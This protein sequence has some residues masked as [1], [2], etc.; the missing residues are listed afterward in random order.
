[1]VVALVAV[2]VV[3]VP[4]TSRAA[5]VVMAPV[6]AMPIVMVPSIVPLA[7]IVMV[8]VPFAALPIAMSVVVPF[9]IPAWTDDNSGRR[10]DVHRWRRCIDRLG[11]IHDTGNANIDAN[12]DVR[13]CDG[14]CAYANAGDECYCQPAMKF[15]FHI[16][17]CNNCLG[18]V[19]TKKQLRRLA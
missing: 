3:T 5:A 6:T 19:L 10:F 9:A 16:S 15:N 18:T 4:V 2:S 13:E 14:G 7:F 1:M 8:L 17:C 11:R 12:V